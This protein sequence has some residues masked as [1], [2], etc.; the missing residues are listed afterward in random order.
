MKMSPKM[1]TT[2]NVYVTVV[3]NLCVNLT[4]LE[5]AQMPTKTSFL[6]AV[7]ASVK[8]RLIRRLRHR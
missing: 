5:D 2:E 8:M 1:M 3:V 7:R 4:G 6:D